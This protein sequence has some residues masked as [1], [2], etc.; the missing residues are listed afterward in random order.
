[1]DPGNP[2]F[3]PASFSYIAIIFVLEVLMAVRLRY[4]QSMGPPHN[5]M[6]MESSSSQ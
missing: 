6:D 2:L 4:Y 3:V 1:M 5:A